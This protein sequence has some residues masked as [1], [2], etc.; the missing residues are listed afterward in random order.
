[1]AR[2]L[3][4]EDDETVQHL[5]GSALFREGYEV[6]YAWNGLEGY[7]KVL[8]LKP[9]LI[10]LDLMLPMMNGVEL[11]KKLKENKAVLDIPVVI[12]TGFGDEANLLG[13]SVRALGA[14]DYLR[15]PIRIEE[16]LGCVKKILLQ[17]QRPKSKAGAGPQELR[18]GVI[19]A[20]PKFRTVWINDRLAATL[21]FKEFALLRCLIKSP[22]PVS[23]GTLLRGL[24][25]RPRQ[26]NALKQAIHRLRGCLGAR[27]G[28]RI[29][30]TPK[31]YE[32][33]G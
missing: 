15:K 18:K 3:S 1:M 16:L 9:D 5:I 23:N 29:Q 8:S 14:A 12:V 24:G 6:H 27:E 13:S 22:G 19:R 7:E 31:G 17:F 26:T 21:S 2:L 30:M 10:L 25:Y 4:I 20:D 32:L 33:I 28:R 11:L